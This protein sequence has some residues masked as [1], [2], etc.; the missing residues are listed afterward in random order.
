M[1]QTRVIFYLISFLLC[2]CAACGDKQEDKSPVK[3]E[4]TVIS[5]ETSPV[6]VR[7]IIEGI[8]VVGTLSPKFQTEIKSEYTGIVDQVFVT[9]WQQV[10]K[11]DALAKLDTREGDILLRKAEAGVEVIKASLAEAQVEANKANR[12]YERLLN[13]HEAGLVTQ[14]NLDDAKSAKEAVEARIKAIKAQIEASEEEVQHAKTRLSKAVIYAPMDGIVA[15][16]SVNVGDLVGEVGSPKV[17]FRIVDNSLLDLTCSVPSWEI[18]KLELG[19]ELAFWTDAIPGQTFNGVINF[20][21]PVVNEADRSNKIIAEV[22]NDPPV[23]KGGL[24]VK[25]LIKTRTR[26]NAMQIPKT[27]LVNWDMDKKKATVF[28]V[29]GDIARQRDIQTGNSASDGVEVMEGLKPEDT[30]VVRGGFQL[31]D[32]D[33]IAII[34]SQ[35]K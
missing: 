33:K 12:E 34:S 7:D 20:I 10:K 32:G 11:G 26:A 19:Q 2:C 8:N 31:K 22:K 27:A 24:F 14:Q 6:T 17:M 16:R 4:H 18:E 21:N 28:V 1:K 15:L 30:I 29:E 23:L 13:L 25:G 3:M 5:V 35:K 9:E